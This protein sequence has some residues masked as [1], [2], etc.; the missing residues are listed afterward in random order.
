MKNKKFQERT[1]VSQQDRDD[2]IKFVSGLS[3]EQRE[4]CGL[5]MASCMA[6]QSNGFCSYNI[7]DGYNNDLNKRL[8]I[9]LIPKEDEQLP[10]SGAVKE[11]TE[12]SD[13][14]RGIIACLAKALPTSYLFKMFFAWSNTIT[15]ASEDGKIEWSESDGTDTYDY[16]LTR[17]KKENEDK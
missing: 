5:A 4:L 8:I 2:L 6:Q 15:K 11:M 16:K 9:M 14:E 1:E 7:N 13:K 12:L 10:V 3:P 17:V